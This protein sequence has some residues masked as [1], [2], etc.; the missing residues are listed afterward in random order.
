MSITSAS[1]VADVLAQYDNNLAWRDDKAKAVLC[2]EAIDWLL[3]H[4]PNAQSMGGR[5]LGYE[6]LLELQKK[7]EARWGLAA[8]A[9]N[10]R[11]RVLRVDFIE[12]Q[13][14]D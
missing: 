8:P 13:G 12:P 11:S 5:T 2:L 1:T 9:A 7:I 10:G 4:R 3:V 6:S 14:V